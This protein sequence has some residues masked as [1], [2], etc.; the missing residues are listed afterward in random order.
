[1]VAAHGRRG[2]SHARNQGARAAGGDLLAFCDADDVVHPTWLEEV[3]QALVD[4]EAVGGRLIGFGSSARFASAR[5]PAT[6]DELPRFMGVPY[7]LTANLGVRRSAFL[8]VGGFD[9]W[10]GTCEDIALSWSLLAAGCS[11]GWAP[12][13]CVD[14]RHRDGVRAMVGQHARYGCGMSQLLLRYG[15]PGVDGSWLR[16]GRL[17]L[18]GNGQPGAARSALSSL[19]RAAIAA[20]R[21]G[22][23][24]TTWP[25]VA[26]GRAP[27]RGGSLGTSRVQ[28]EA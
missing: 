10:L 5:P 27:S 26:T 20:G 22:G 21:M 7:I 13:A 4:H 16:P 1:V 17:L 9:E 14:Y 2:P 25:A 6:P 8:A 3:S 28:Q 24:V 12:E 15:I 19:R 23:L 18:R 11:L